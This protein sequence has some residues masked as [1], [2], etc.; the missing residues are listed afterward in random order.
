MGFDDLSKERNFKLNPPT[1]APGQGVDEYSEGFGMSSGNDIDWNSMYN[2]MSEPAAESNWGSTTMANSGWNDGTKSGASGSSGSDAFPVAGSSWNGSNNAGGSISTGIENSPWANT[3]S[4]WSAMGVQQ[5][6]QTPQLQGRDRFEDAMY[7]LA[8]SAGKEG[9]VFLKLLFGSQKTQTAA[10]YRNFFRSMM[11]MSA[12]V[13]GLSFIVSIMW[14]LTPWGYAPPNGMFFGG[15]LGGFVGVLGFFSKRYYKAREVKQEAPVGVSGSEEKGFPLADVGADDP[16]EIEEVDPWSVDETDSGEDDD[17]DL[18][19]F[20]QDI[21]EESK[22][23]VVATDG[24]GSGEVDLSA[25]DVGV[26]TRKL[27][28]DLMKEYLP[29][30]FPNFKEEVEL[31]E[32]SQKFLDF[33]DKIKESGEAVNLADEDIPILYR[34]METSYVT[35]L[36]CKVLGAMKNTNQLADALESNLKFDDMGRVVDPNVKVNAIKVNKN[37]YFKIL[38]NQPKLLLQGDLLHD[39]EV[40]DFYSDPANKLPITWG[41]DEEGFIFNTDISKVTSLIIAGRSRSGKTEMIIRLLMTMAWLSSPEELN[42]MFFSTKANSDF[43]MFKEMPHTVGYEGDAHKYDSILRWAI[44]VEGQ[45]RR[46][47]LEKYGFNNVNNFN[48]NLPEG[49]KIIPQLW[50]VIDE[51][52]NIRKHLSDEEYKDFLK[53]VSVLAT[54]LPFLNIKLLMCPHRITNEMIPKGVYELVDCRIM[55]RSSTS[56]LKDGIEA[57]DKSFPYRLTHE[58]E[59]AMKFGGINGGEPKYLY[60]PLLVKEG[61]NPEVARRITEIWNKILPDFQKPTM[62]EILGGNDPTG[63]EEME[64]FLEGVQASDSADEAPEEV[65]EASDEAYREDVE[66]V[67]SVE[68]DESNP[69]IDEEASESSDSDEEDDFWDSL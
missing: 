34:V 14:K 1:Y 59:L 61:G 17:F 5:N 2:D 49:E 31:N 51:M 21:E 45:R 47:I 15:A 54:E 57:T 40:Y 6:Q 3:G 19:S 69:E 42:M 16:E 53:S 11:R 32:N 43:S 12:V 65:V 68:N 46:D 26:Y 22:E 62:G 37:V 58:G 20:F 60:S 66:V 64:K 67:E 63:Y 50:I 35:T 33:Y 55:V 44:Y 27:L 56:D 13:V 28:V 8:E 23:V 24:S 7:S 41:I 52:G 39:K 30:H 18:D 4:P 10:G 38:W 48:K 29:T 25:L 36:H 9:W